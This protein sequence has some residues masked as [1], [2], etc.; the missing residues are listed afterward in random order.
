MTRIRSLRQDYDIHR[1]RAGYR[2]VEFKLTFEEW[3][4]IWE[5]SGHL[6]ERGKGTGS[7]VMGRHG[8]KGPYAVGNVTIIRMKD[9][10]R[11]AHTGGV[12]L[13]TNNNAKK[14]KLRV[15]VRI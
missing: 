12:F 10:I 11:E 8:D 6:Y 13:K 3:L 4:K 1:R 7:Y 2:G 14:Q 9:N 15:R 5:D